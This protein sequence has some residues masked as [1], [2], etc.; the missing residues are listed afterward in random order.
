MQIVSFLQ[1]SPFSQ[2]IYHDGPSFLFFE[3]ICY[4]LRLVA[5]GGIFK[6]LLA[7]GNFLIF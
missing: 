2:A 6:K 7:D 5:W 4:N 1:G 3:T